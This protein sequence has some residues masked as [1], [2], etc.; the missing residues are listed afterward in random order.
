MRK[1]GCS[2]FLDVARVA[3]ILK[4]VAGRSPLWL[5]HRHRVFFAMLRFLSVLVISAGMCHAGESPV[6]PPRDPAYKLVWADEFQTDGPPDPAKWRSES[7]FCRNEEL[8]WYQSENSRCQDG[9]LIIEARREKVPNPNHVS[10]SAKWEEK[11]S[12]AN[13]TSGSLVTFGR[14][15]WSL[16]RYEIRARFNPLP[17]LWPAIWTTGRGRWPHGGEIDIMEFYQD[18]IL[19]NFV[20]A[21]KGGRD[22][23]DDSKHP[24]NEFDPKS[25]NEK[26][27]VW[28]MEWTR[29]KIDIHLDGRLLNSLVLRDVVNQDGPAINPFLSP[30][31]FRL[32]LAIGA[33]AGDPSG[34]PFP[35]RYE[36][37]YVRIYQK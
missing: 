22:F 34:T 23:W 29:E 27:H 15:A 14:H 5:T 9:L 3:M 10:G 19:A 16:G 30:H 17:G 33:L 13:Y 12:H 2:E 7:G 1:A 24:I 21:G 35:Q 26:F 11:R 6:L 18:K 28:V 25:W 20:W 31:H 32:N 4:E 37:D 8:Q 36:V